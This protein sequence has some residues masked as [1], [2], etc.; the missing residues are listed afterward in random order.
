MEKIGWEPEQPKQLKQLKQLEATPSR[1]SRS[2]K[3]VALVKGYGSQCFFIFFFFFFCF[4]FFFFLELM[5]GL[6]GPYRSC[7][8]FSHDHD[9]RPPPQHRNPQRPLL[10]FHPPI[11]LTQHPSNPNVPPSPLTSSSDSQLIRQPL[12]ITPADSW[13]HRRFN[14]TILE[15][16]ARFN[17]IYGRPHQPIPLPSLNIDN[18][19]QYDTAS[20][21]SSVK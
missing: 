20:I 9:S 5:T 13:H 2:N 10:S 11:K 6:S 17:A 4:F 8:L 19:I 12:P 18:T 3:S 15:P 7:L 21:I 1:S 14:P 16:T